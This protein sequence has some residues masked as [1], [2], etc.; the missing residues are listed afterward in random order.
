MAKTAKNYRKADQIAE[1]LVNRFK[2]YIDD[3][4]RTYSTEIWD[5]ERTCEK[6]D[7]EDATFEEEIAKLVKKRATAK[8]TRSYRVADQIREELREKW[9][10]EVDDRSR[11]WARE[12]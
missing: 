3:A 2:V 8:Y 11:S 5:Y 9:N 12:F 1:E 7:D 10:V 6:A 4:K